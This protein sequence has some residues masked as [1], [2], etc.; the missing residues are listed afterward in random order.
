LQRRHGMPDA[1]PVDTALYGARVLSRLRASAEQ[2]EFSYPETIGNGRQLP[3]ALLQGVGKEA[4]G[5]DPGWHAAT[6]CE[7]ASLKSVADRVPPVAPGEKIARGAST[8]DWQTREPFAAFAYGRLGARWLPV[9]TAGLPANVRG[10]L[11]HDVLAG[12]YEGVQ[13]QFAIAA[14]SGDQKARRISVAV[15]GAFAKHE[16]YADAQLAEILRLERD[17]AETLAARVVEVDCERGPFTIVSIEESIDAN[18]AGL[19]L[20]LR[21]DRIDRLTDGSLVILD[22]KTGRYRKFL[23]KGAPADL[24]LVVYASVMDSPVSGLGLFNVDSQHVE[25][26]GAGPGLWREDNWDESL[27][28]WMHQVSTAAGEIVMGDARMNVGQKLEDARP[29]ALLSRIAEVRRE[30]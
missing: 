21:C 26:N 12:L 5:V 15:D 28:E 16:R 22:Y 20:T 11:I 7:N 6:L 17:R 14:W 8:I 25:I 24:Q 30:Q 10:I 18:I 2:C 29:L 13:D 9:F 4:V 3:T 27:G 1:D 23:V 19:N